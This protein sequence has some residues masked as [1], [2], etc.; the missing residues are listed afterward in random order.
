MSDLDSLAV[1]EDLMRFNREGLLVTPESPSKGPDM[2][3][4]GALYHAARALAERCGV[5]LKY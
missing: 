1:I 5:E 3:Y 2:L 4:D